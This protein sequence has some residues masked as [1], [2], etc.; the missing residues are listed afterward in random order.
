MAEYRQPE[1]TDQPTIDDD[2]V[3]LLYPNDVQA[4]RAADTVTFHS[5]PDGVG[6]IDASLTTAAFAD[7]RIY[8]VR[9]QRLFPEGFRL[10]RRRRI[11]VAADIA[12][13]DANRRWHEH[14]LP[15][16]SAVT[17]IDAA[18]LHEV[19]QS[20][21]GLLR[22]SDLLRLQWRADDPADEPHDLE[23]HRDVLRV[24]VTRG[25]R[26]WM[27]LLDVQVR[28]DPVRMITAPVSTPDQGRP[29]ANASE[30]AAATG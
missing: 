21:A 3:G 25:Q 26:R 22:P 24:G 14:Q 9:E 2:P 5:S 17:V 4:L 8:T 13:F 27:F 10:D 7:L 11:A 16:A 20:V 6:W 23:L 1:P 29:L 19:W 18:Q 28:P 30:T 12:G 15:G